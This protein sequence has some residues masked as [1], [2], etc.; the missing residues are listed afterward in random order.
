MSVHL[1]RK[2]NPAFWVQLNPAELRSAQS[3]LLDP[4]PSYQLFVIHQ[5]LLCTNL[6][7]VSQIETQSIYK[8]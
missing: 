7:K 2:P 3:K 4:A 1:R 6:V 8:S 5:F